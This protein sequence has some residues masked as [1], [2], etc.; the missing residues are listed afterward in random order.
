MCVL[1]CDQEWQ[2]KAMYMVG[3]DIHYELCLWRILSSR[4]YLGGVLFA[5][6]CRSVTTLLKQFLNWHMHLCD[7]TAKL[8]NVLL[9]RLAW[10]NMLSVNSV[11]VRICNTLSLFTVL[12]IPWPID[13]VSYSY[14]LGLLLNYVYD[15]NIRLSLPYYCYSL[16]NNQIDIAI[17]FYLMF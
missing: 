2:R 14:E 16:N 4:L 6:V 5:I 1:C 11:A 10:M 15:K 17:N 12:W 9:T 13:A 8:V 3:I 7:S